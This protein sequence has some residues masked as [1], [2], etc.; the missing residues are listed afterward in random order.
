MATTNYLNHAQQRVLQTLATLIGRGSQGAL[1][2][3]IAEAIGTLASN[4]TRD[5]ANLRH[6]GFARSIDGRWYPTVPGT[7]ARLTS[8]AE[9]QQPRKIGNL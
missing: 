2:G 8:R 6:V 1:P 5:L 9:D 3:E 4:T 7:S